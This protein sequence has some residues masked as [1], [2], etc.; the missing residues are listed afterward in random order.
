MEEFIQSLSIKRLCLPSETNYHY[1]RSGKIKNSCCC[2][3]NSNHIAVC[4]NGKFSKKVNSLKILSYG[5][6]IYD[7]SCGLKSKHAEVTAINNLP[8]QSK[9]KKNPTKINILVLRVSTTGKLGISKPCFHCILNMNSLP[10]RGYII[11]DI[12]YSNENE[13]IVKT[14]LNKIISEGNFH[15]T[16]YYKTHDF[17]LK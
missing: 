13:E 10:T 9:N 15:I 16:K 11:K 5:T 7:Y 3:G 2:D 14:S 6:N 17:K 12:L 8:S 4:F 1:L